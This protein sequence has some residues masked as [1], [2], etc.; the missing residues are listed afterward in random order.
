V[1]RNFANDW[2]AIMSN[3]ATFT[4]ATRRITSC[5]T[6]G[7]RVLRAAM[8]TWL[9]VITLVQRSRAGTVVKRRTRLREGTERRTSARVPVSRR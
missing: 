6:L 3:G 4:E 8:R 9:T 1:A 7:L 5:I 2:A